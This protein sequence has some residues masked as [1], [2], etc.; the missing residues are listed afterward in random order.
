MTVVR[1]QIRGCERAEVTLFAEVPGVTVA[2]GTELRTDP[3][4]PGFVHIPWWTRLWRALT[5]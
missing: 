5:R 4:G 2:H 1:V 3:G